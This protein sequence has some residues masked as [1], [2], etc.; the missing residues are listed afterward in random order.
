MMLQ[1]WN[2]IIINYQGGIMD[3]FYN[4]DLVKSVRNIVPYMSLDVLSVGNAKGVNGQVCNVMYYDYALEI[5]RIKYLYN[6]VKS[7]NPPILPYSD[8]NK[9]L[10]K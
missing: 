9:T 3:I 1:K 6:S 10:L 5:D 8:T 7:S 4:G 2:N